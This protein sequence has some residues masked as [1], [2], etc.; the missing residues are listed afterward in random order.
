[1]RI[2]LLTAFACSAMMAQSDGF[3][4]LMPN[5]DVTE[6]WII[7]GTPADTWRVEDGMIRCTGTP[8][9]V[10]RSKKPVCVRSAAN[11]VETD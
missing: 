11:A 3:V 9:G 10:A 8:V 5:K 2:F 7:E 6:H 1:M 4:S